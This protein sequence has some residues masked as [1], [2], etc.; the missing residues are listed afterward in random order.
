MDWNQTINQMVTYIEVNL[1]NEITIEK[2]AEICHYSTFYTQKLFHIAT[3]FTFKEYVR[4][5]RLSEAAVQLQQNKERVTDVALSFGYENNESF[6]R[7]FRQFHGCTPSEARDGGC[8]VSYFPPIRLTLEVKGGMTMEY[9]I[10]EQG[11]MKIVGVKEHYQDFDEGIKRIP[12]F[13]E[14]FN[15]SNTEIELCDIAEKDLIYGVCISDPDSSAYDYLIGVQS[16]ATTT[17]EVVEIPASRWLVFSARGKLPESVQT[18][19]REIF[20][21]FLPNADFVVKDAPEMEVYP[22][23]DPDSEHYVTEIWVAI[24]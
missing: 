5:R 18:T 12:S 14:T 17:Y 22:L 10:E 6:S 21:H 13:W 8:S 24:E 11:I 1:E 7:A 2:L 9:R 4:K 19:T 3:G 20:E 16:S 23:G 15:G